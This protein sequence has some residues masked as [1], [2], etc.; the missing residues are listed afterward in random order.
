MYTS[1]VL[2]AFRS[3]AYTAT[4]QFIAFCLSVINAGQAT[5]RWFETDEVIAPLLIL[6]AQ[7]AFLLVALTVKHFVL[8]VVKFFRLAHMGFEFYCEQVVDAAVQVAEDAIASGELLLLPA[9]AGQD[10]VAAQSDEL[11]NWA[12]ARWPQ[13]A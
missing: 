7:I 12:K 6:I 1:I 8:G 2:A 13:L 9:A 3:T 5:R 10:S 11:I 4:V